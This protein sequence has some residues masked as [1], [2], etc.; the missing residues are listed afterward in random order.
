VKREVR[1]SLKS[2]VLELAVYAALVSGYFFLVLKFLADWLSRIF[3]SDRTLYAALALGLILAQGL[4][5]ELM[6]RLLLGWI[7]ARM[8]D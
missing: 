7:K 8:E 6:T 2:F 1:S 5:L 3:E 4:L